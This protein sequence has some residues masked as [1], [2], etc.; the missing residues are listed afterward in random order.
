MTARERLRQVYLRCVKYATD[1]NEPDIVALL[2][3]QNAARIAKVLLHGS[4][5]DCQARVDLLLKAAPELFPS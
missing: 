5:Y 3:A 4:D 1:S 2:A